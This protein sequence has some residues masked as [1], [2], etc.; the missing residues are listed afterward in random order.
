[1]LRSLSSQVLEISPDSLDY[2][3]H[4]LTVLKRKSFLLTSRWNLFWFSLWCYYSPFHH[5]QVQRPLFCLDDPLRDTVKLLPCPWNSALLQTV[6]APFPLLLSQDS[7][8]AP[9]HPMITGMSIQ[10]NIL[11]ALL[12]YVY[13]VHLWGRAHPHTAHHQALSLWVSSQVQYITWTLAEFHE[14]IPQHV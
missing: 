4:C 12:N 5:R 13:T 3:F 11:D 14:S 1:M 2:L 9:A 8:P 6:Q 10:P 7:A